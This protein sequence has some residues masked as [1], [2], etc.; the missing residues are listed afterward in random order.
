MPI[1]L[2]TARVLVISIFA[3]WLGAVLNERIPALGRLSIPAP[4]TGGLPV[5][6]LLSLVTWVTGVDLEWDLQLRDTLLLVFFSGVGLSAKLGRLKEGGRLFVKLAI[7]VVIFLVLQNLVGMGVA[8]ALGR[9][10]AYGLVAGSVALAGGHGTAI[11]WGLVGEE[12]GYTAAL[13]HGLAFAT[14]GL[15]AGATLGGPFASWIIK[16]N[17]LAEPVDLHG[18]RGDSS[19]EPEEAGTEETPLSSRKVLLTI[20]LLALCTAIGAE[21]NSLVGDAGLLLPGFVTAMLAG[22][23]LTNLV[24]FMRLPIFEGAVDLIQDVSLHLFLAMT[25]VSLEIAQLATALTPLSI[26]LSAQVCFAAAFSLWVVF[27]RCGRDYD[28]AVLASGFVGIGLGATPVG[29]ANMESVTKRFGP[30]PRALLVLPLIG[31]GVLDMVN[32]LI[33]SGFVRVLL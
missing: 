29:M 14:F 8:L 9:H 21:I 10:P 32:A 24:D 13:P 5:A 16:R 30:S 6:I 31:A 15:I 27:P 3:L 12:M 11:T 25:L 1:E 20:L 26:G 33:I 18:L 19:V 4:V 2:T 28:A 23:L 17:G 22:V 7:I